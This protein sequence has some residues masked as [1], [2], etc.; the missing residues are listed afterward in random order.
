VPI[1]PKRSDVLL[2]DGHAVLDEGGEL[3]RVEG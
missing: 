3:V 1:K 2:V